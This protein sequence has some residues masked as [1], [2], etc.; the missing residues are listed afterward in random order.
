MFLVDWWNSLGIASQIFYCVAIPAT[1]VLL[2]QTVLMFI[3][4]GNDA[5]GVGDGTPDD[6]GDVVPDDIGNVPEL[7]DIS[8]LADLKI[9]TLRGI[10][11]FFVVFG[12]V[13]IAM[14]AAG[15][16]LFITIPISIVCG[17][18]MM[19]LIAIMMKA[20]MKLRADGNTDNRNAIGTAGRV[21]LVIPPER[22]G[23]G[24]VH[25]MLQGAYVERDAVTDDSEA[26]PTGAEII[27]IGVS[28]QTDLV[29][30]RK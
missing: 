25:I 12:W 11:A 27:V 20:V 7:E 24:K 13:G 14:D 28:G 21:Q 23:S 15:A 3:G 1:L 22:T 30:K 8:E 26:I 10:V 4:L 5:D 29:V 16:Q 6:I 17:V 19:I 2:I 9:F 18:A